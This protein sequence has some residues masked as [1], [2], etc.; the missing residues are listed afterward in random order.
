MSDHLIGK[1]E[2][3]IVGAGP[4]A[5]DY[6]RVLLH[7]GVTPTVIGRGKISAKRFEDET[8]ISVEREGLQKF[9]NRK[10]PSK[11]TSIIIAVGTEAL[12]PSLIEFIKL[13]FGRI[14]I[15]KPAAI[16]I[17]ELLANEELLRPI[18]DKVFVAYNRRFYLAVKKAIELIEEDGGL[19]SLHFEFTEWA[20]KIDPLVKAPGVKENWFFANSTHVIDLAFFIAG[21]PVNMSSYSESG[22]LKWHERSRFCGAGICENGVLFSYN[23]NWESAGNWSLDLRTD[24]RRYVLNPLEQIRYQDRGS[25]DWNEIDLKRGKFKEG[26]YS[27]VQDILWSDNIKC[28]SLKEHYWNTEF[29]YKKILDGEY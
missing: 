21:R 14:L 10:K 15:E 18:Q 27:L 22:H 4:M 20:H 9:L 5:M 17:E 11:E 7:L 19:Q 24:K 2:I 25:L 16:S 3:W 29:V 1:K 8:G 23:S 12:I 6:A 13:D 28:C 26:M